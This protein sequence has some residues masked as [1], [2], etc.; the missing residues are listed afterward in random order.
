MEGNEWVWIRLVLSGI[1]DECNQLV[2]DIVAIWER[3]LEE[4]GI[5]ER[6]KSWACCHWY[7]KEV[8]TLVNFQAKEYRVFIY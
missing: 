8:L 7:Q 5:W 2:C 6:L 4:N 3:E 1:D